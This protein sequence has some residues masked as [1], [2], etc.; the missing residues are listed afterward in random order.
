MNN[1]YE[2]FNTHARIRKAKDPDDLIVLHEPE[3]KLKEFPSFANRK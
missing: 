1:L 2:I 3:A